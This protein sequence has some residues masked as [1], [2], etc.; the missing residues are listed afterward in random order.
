MSHTH[1]ITLF[2]NE[3][4]ND[5]KTNQK[6]ELISRLDSRTLRPVNILGLLVFSNNIKNGISDIRYIKRRIMAWPWNLAKG[7]SKVIK[8]TPFDRSHTSS[9]SSSIVTM[10]V[11]CTVFKIK[12]DI[13]RK[14]PICHSYP[15]YLTCTIP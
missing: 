5:S 12:R 2:T 8:I 9:Y 13:R 15:L 1:T 14:T 11:F 4:Q 3:C 6:Q 10:A 7:S